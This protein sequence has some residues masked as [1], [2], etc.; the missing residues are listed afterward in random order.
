MLFFSWCS[1]LSQTH[2]EEAKEL[3]PVKEE[4]LIV[5]S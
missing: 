4:I 1:F 2:M 3:S 5:D